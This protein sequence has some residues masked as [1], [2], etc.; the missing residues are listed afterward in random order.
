[1]ILKLDEMMYPAAFLPVLEEE[2]A[3][4]VKIEIIEKKQLFYIVEIE[5]GKPEI[6][7]KLLTKIFLNRFLEI[8]TEQNYG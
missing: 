5:S 2:F 7:I 8:A 4:E 6:D 1:M 3:N